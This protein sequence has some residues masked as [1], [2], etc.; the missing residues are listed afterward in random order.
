MPFAIIY[1]HLSVPRMAL[2]NSLSDTERVATPSAPI[3]PNLC[4]QRMRVPHRRSVC[5]RQQRNLR[6]CQRRHKTKRR[7]AREYQAHC[8]NIQRLCLCIWHSTNAPSPRPRSQY[9]RSSHWR[10][11]RRIGHRATAPRAV[12]ALE[13]RIEISCSVA[14]VRK[15]EL[16]FAASPTTFS[17]M[18]R[19]NVSE[20]RV[21]LQNGGEQMCVEV[22]CVVCN[23]CCERLAR[24]NVSSSFVS[25]TLT[26]L[27]ARVCVRALRASTGAVSRSSSARGAPNI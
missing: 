17:S 14:A 13:V 20:M 27:S 26:T 15:F 21:H 6:L 8:K 23:V 16:E 24:R 12:S 19:S 22:G 11:R 9:C 10:R 7:C 2:T 25:S 5:C 4:P 18:A 1:C 3:R